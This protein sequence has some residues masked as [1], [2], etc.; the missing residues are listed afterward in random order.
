MPKG[1]RGGQEWLPPGGGQ[2]VCAGG[3]LG[4]TTKVSLLFLGWEFT[5]VFTS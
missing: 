1:G 4:G 5:Q 2:G 3:V